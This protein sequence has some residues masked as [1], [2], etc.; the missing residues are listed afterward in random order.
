MAGQEATLLWGLFDNELYVKFKNEKHEP[1]HPEEGRPLPFGKF[2]KHKKS[3]VEIKADRIGQ[4]AKAISLPRS[5][6][7]DGNSSDQALLTQ[8]NIP[9]LEKPNSTP[10]DDSHF[11]QSATFKNKLDAKTAIA[12]YLGKPLSRLTDLQMAATNTILDE[13]LDKKAV[14]EKV[15]AYSTLSSVGRLGR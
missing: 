12:D 1:F 5:A 3:S 9:H 13:S 4:L 14:L 10:F 11:L 7:S 8:A 6:L 2:R 15:R